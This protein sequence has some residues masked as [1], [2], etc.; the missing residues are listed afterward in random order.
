[1]KLEKQLEKMKTLVENKQEMAIWRK[2]LYDETKINC[3]I[4][5]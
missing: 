1:M 5:K 2:V 4:L 3:Q